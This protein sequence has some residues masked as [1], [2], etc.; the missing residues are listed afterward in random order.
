M[1]N[2]ET[3]KPP[4]VRNADPQRSGKLQKSPVNRIPEILALGGE[5][6]RA[7][8]LFRR[9]GSFKGVAN[10]YR[11]NGQCNQGA[12]FLARENLFEEL[13]EYLKL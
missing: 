9:A 1:R 11:L 6:E 3:L 10:A 12:S 2:L 13:V 5:H 4:Q 8:E 7:V